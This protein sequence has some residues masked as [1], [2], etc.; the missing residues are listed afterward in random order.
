MPFSKTSD[1]RSANLTTNQNRTVNRMTVSE[2]RSNQ[3]KTIKKLDTGENVSSQTDLFQ[4]PVR[5]GRRLK[6][7]LIETA[8]HQLKRTKIIETP[9]LRQPLITI[10]TL[11]DIAGVDEV[12]FS[13]PRDYRALKLEIQ[14][15]NIVQSQMDTE[16]FKIDSQTKGKNST[17][18]CDEELL[19]DS[20]SLI[21]SKRK[22][23]IKRQRANS[24][25]NSKVHYEQSSCGSS[26]MISPLPHDNTPYNNWS[27]GKDPP[28]NCNDTV[29]DRNSK[30]I[31]LHDHLSVSQPNTPYKNSPGQLSSN[32]VCLIE[33]T[34]DEKDFSAFNEKPP[35]CGNTMILDSL[36][37]DTEDIFDTNSTRINRRLKG[38]KTIIDEKV[39]PTSKNNDHCIVAQYST[40]NVSNSPT[41]NREENRDRAILTNL[42]EDIFDIDDE[43]FKE[44]VNLQSAEGN[45]PS[46][47][48]D[49]DV[50]LQALQD[51][52]EDSASNRNAKV[53]QPNAQ[54]KNGPTYENNNI[55]DINS[56]LQSPC[57]TS[58]HRVSNKISDESTCI[59]EKWFFNHEYVKNGVKRILCTL[60]GKERYVVAAILNTE[61]YIYLQNKDTW[62]LLRKFKRFEGDTMNSHT[63][64]TFVLLS[65]HSNT[66]D[67][68]VCLKS[69]AV[70]KEG[71]MQFLKEYSYY[72]YFNLE[73]ID[74]IE[75]SSSEDEIYGER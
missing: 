44:R 5:K 57:S 64:N 25:R 2:G 16:I 42:S 36:V 65:T 18:A 21:S 27:L 69:F 52:C 73:S 7:T 28:E 38:T 10:P 19:P 72:S 45:A 23:R 53:F 3:R 41:N 6:R 63:S 47:W 22:P 66:L 54:L 4:T 59:V 71:E 17:L 14:R 29:N 48:S 43:V 1:I 55:S 51:V 67:C 74:D 50:C 8:Q 35:S 13:L 58:Q 11:A 56:T 40:S 31:M 34:C 15:E 61:A 62:K 20:P 60:V 12:E 75:S 39:P 37:C 9:K 33:E 26:G 30:I 46:S 49:N 24:N 70:S 68:Y 32:P